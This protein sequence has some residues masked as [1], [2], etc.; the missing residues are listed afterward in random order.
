MN[1]SIENKM[2][3]GGVYDY[4]TKDGTHEE[5]M[6]FEGFSKNGNDLTMN[7]RDP[8]NGLKKS[9]KASEIDKLYRDNQWMKEKL[10]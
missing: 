7:F 9:V 4:D 1:H 5:T 3:V 2:G 10:I 8:D 6:V